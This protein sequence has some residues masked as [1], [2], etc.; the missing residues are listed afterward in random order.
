MGCTIYSTKNKKKLYSNYTYKYLRK[1][2]FYELI[3]EVTGDILFSL[4][5]YSLLLSFN[6]NKNK[7]FRRFK[8]KYSMQK[9]F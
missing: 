1:G 5:F 6:R 8:S 3:P 2:F 9:F 7:I 4:I